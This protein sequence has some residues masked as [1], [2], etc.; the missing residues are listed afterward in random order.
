MWKKFSVFLLALLVVSCC[1]W[2]FPGRPTSSTA[3]D[4]APAAIQAVDIPADEP[5]PASGMI[6]IVDST[7]P[8]TLQGDQAPAVETAPEVTP[9]LTAEETAELNAELVAIQ[10]DV[11]V[12]REASDAK[13]A[14]IDSLEADNTALQE[15]LA[16]A[17]DETGTKTY[18]MVESI[19][20]F[21]DMMPT[22]GAGL[23]LGARIGDNLMLEFG[24]D[25]DL[26]KMMDF[27]LNRWTFRAGLGWMF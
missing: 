10:E 15:D 12:L 23:T 5:S 4:T 11:K 18:L 21:E 8:S 2:A 20:G 19:V 13:D 9:A 7:E 17:L 26:N 6:S 14:L 27:S 24:V 25:Y 3:T 1:A 16:G 22:Y